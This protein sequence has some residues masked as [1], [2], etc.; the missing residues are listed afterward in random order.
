[1]FGDFDDRS[2][3]VARVQG[4][5]HSVVDHRPRRR[6]DR[7]RDSVGQGWEGRNR[8]LDDGQLEIGAEAD[9]RGIREPLVGDRYG[10]GAK[11]HRAS[12]LVSSMVPRS[13]M[14]WKTIS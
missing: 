6:V 5:R 13:K 9:R 2:M 14:G 8:R 1:M 7:Q 10:A 11:R 12:Q 4:L 3:G